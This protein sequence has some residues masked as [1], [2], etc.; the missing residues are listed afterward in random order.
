[1][2]PSERRSLPTDEADDARSGEGRYRVSDDVCVSGR[3]TRSA[4]SV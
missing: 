4:V 3:S 2:S 1:M